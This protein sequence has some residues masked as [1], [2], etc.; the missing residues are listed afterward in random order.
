M[1]NKLLFSIAIIIALLITISS[2]LSDEPIPAPEPVPPSSGGSGGGSSGGGSS[3]GIEIEHMRIEYPIILNAESECRLYLWNNK[4]EEVYNV[5]YTIYEEIENGNTIISN[6]IAHGTIEEIEEHDGKT[7]LFNWIP[8]SVNTKKLI[9]IVNINGTESSYEREIYH[10]SSETGYDLDISSEMISDE[11]EIFVNQNFFMNLT[12]RNRGPDTSDY[13]T[14]NIYILENM[15]QY[16]GENEEEITSHLE[17]VESANLNQL[18][19][20]E[21][22]SYTLSP[23]FDSPGF[24]LIYFN[25]SNGNDLFRGNSE[26]GEEI[27]VRTHGADVLGFIDLH[28]RL[29]VGYENEIEVELLNIG[30]QDAESIIV[31]LYDGTTL[32]GTQTLEEIEEM[33]HDEVEF[34]WTPQ[35]TGE[36]TLRL[37]VTCYN[38][39]YLE[40]NE[41]SITVQVQEPEFPVDEFEPDNTWQQATTISTNNVVQEH[42][43]FPNRDEDYFNFHAEQGITYIM[44]TLEIS[45]DTYMELFDTDG[46]TRLISNDDYQGLRSRIEWTCDQTGMYYVMIRQLGSRMNGDYKFTIYPINF[47]QPKMDWFDGD[48]TDLSQ[49]DLSNVDN[50]VLENTQNGKIDFSGKSLDLSKTLNIN[51]YVKITEATIF[52]DSNNIPALNQPARLTMYNLKFTEPKIMKDGK[53]C[54]ECS[55]ISYENNQLIFDVPH[56]TTYQAVEGRQNVGSYSRKFGPKQHVKMN[57]VTMNDQFEQ[58]EDL[59]VRV[60]MNNDGETKLKDVSVTIVIQELNVRRKIGPFDLKKEEDINQLVLAEMPENVKPGDYDVRITISNDFMKRVKYRTITII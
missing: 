19:P 31:S 33:D 29:T 7:V 59:Q 60:T 57:K 56:F 53:E 11:E 21:R 16:W 12:I 5:T 32:I 34:S 27:I 23:E 36:H 39:A 58:G 42:T 45:G 43:N 6:Q 38:D 37:M 9:V 54:S 24:H 20:Y 47:N 52:I 44:E 28:G 51:D 3:F 40:D 48:T 26:E 46:E 50:L 35:S 41:M 17:F 15:M 30:D 14:L 8:H 2:A 10:V 25:L 22:V 13:E 4:N 18:Q 49:A 55:I 1:K